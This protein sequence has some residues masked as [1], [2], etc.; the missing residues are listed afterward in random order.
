MLYDQEKQ[1]GNAN[2]A[3]L[4]VARKSVAYLMAVA[5]CA[6]ICSLRIVIQQS[7][8]KRSATFVLGTAGLAVDVLNMGTSRTQF[9]GSFLSFSTFILL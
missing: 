7:H 2:R 8:L 5:D 1:K 3:P 6:R 9:H 4:A